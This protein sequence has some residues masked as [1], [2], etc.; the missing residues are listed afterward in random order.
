[1]S[2][3]MG[4]PAGRSPS[5][6]FRIFFPPF[7]HLEEDYQPRRNSIR[8]FISLADLCTPIQQICSIQLVLPPSL[9]DGCRS[10]RRSDRYFICITVCWLGSCLCKKEKTKQGKKLCDMDTW[11]IRPCMDIELHARRSP[12]MSLLDLKSDKYAPPKT[13]TM[14]R[15]FLLF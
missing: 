1:M 3:F 15:F 4:P 10:R 12:K 9:D 11:A 2:L 14:F 5:C 13:C 8:A 7:H 6:I